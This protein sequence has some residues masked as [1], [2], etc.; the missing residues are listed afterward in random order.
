MARQDD[1]TPSRARE[2]ADSVRNRRRILAA[3]IELFALRADAT[4]DEIAAAAGLTRATVYRHFPVREALLR[5]VVAQVAEEALPDLF[6][7]MEARPLHDALDHL[8]SWVVATAREHQHLLEA[9][10][11][12]LE[13]IG[14]AAVPDEP[15]ADFLARRREVGELRS[16]LS[17]GWLARTVRV[18]CL[19]AAA[20]DRPADEVVGELSVSLRRLAT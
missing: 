18:L 6:A 5:A 17:D 14:R 19:I 4:V 13:E 20:D 8:A 9:H 2:R 16:P 1:G 7:A 12:H 11:P 10:L 3:A 15:V